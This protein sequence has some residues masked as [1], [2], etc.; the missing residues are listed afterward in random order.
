MEKQKV[1]IRKQKDLAKLILS[2]YEVELEDENSD[3][4]YVKFHGPKDTPYEGVS[5]LH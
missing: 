4:F 3:A 1:N 5:S 2:K